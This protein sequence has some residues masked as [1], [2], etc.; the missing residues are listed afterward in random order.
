M[1][2]FS[3]KILGNPEILSTLASESLIKVESK[4]LNTD[5][6]A[7]LLASFRSGFEAI[8]YRLEKEDFRG[9]NKVQ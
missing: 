9:F 1:V 4:I 2:S 5:A 7:K 6:G 3:L 8:K